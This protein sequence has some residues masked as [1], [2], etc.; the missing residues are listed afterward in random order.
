M[1]RIVTEL[2]K[3]L[4]PESP[5]S[6]LPKGTISE[7]V[8]GRE[9]HRQ[10][11]IDEVGICDVKVPLTVG[12]IE[13]RPAT[14]TVQAT[15]DISV[16]LAAEHKG[17]HMSRLIESLLDAPQPFTL[18]HIAALLQDLLQRQ[19][20]THATINLRFDYFLSRVAPVSLKA[21]PQAYAVTLGGTLTPEGI[22][23]Y[24]QVDVLVKTLCPCSKEISDYGAHN[25]RGCIGIRLEH[26]QPQAIDICLEEMIEHAEACASSP[27]FPILKRSDERHVTMLAYDNPRF[28]EDVVRDVVTGLKKEVRCDAY[29]VR[30]TNFESIHAHNAFASIK[31]RPNK[32]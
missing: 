11:A 27:L 20:A 24:Q 16:N 32:A 28:V 7:D 8:Q 25:Q 12:G 10:V 5:N 1:P 4:K 9:D 13:K 18:S 29:E 6:A 2:S 23:V 22:R 19:K 31:G 15:V 17:I 3:F 26:A 30:V 14:Q 21:A